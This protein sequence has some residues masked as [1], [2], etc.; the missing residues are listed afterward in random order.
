[1][2]KIASKYRFKYPELYNDLRCSES[3]PCSAYCLPKDHK[4][5]PGLKD[6]PI[7]AATDTP[8]TSL[9]RYLAKSLLMLLKHVPAH[10]KNTE[11][12]INFISNIDDNPV[13]GFCSLNV[14][15]LYESMPLVD[16][17]DHTPSIFTIVRRFFHQHKADCQLHALNDKE[18]EGLVR[19]CLTSDEVLIYGKG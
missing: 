9:S 10:L 15:N 18:F 13:Q 11:E 3:L 6:E 19:L 17:D 4:K 12:L 16:I 2:N 8:A 5:G 14:C 7:H 1:M